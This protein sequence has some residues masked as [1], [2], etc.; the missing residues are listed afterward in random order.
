M[1]QQSRIKQSDA[2]TL[3]QQGGNELAQTTEN[4]AANQIQERDE[5]EPPRQHEQ[6][7]NLRNR[8]TYTTWHRHQLLPDTRQIWKTNT[9]K[10][11]S[12]GLSEL[13]C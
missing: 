7:W 3:E 4:K 12:L 1:E 9:K 11:L 8:L 13:Q 5:D 10:M 6:Q 2:G